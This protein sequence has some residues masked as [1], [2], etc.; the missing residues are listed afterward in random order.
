MFAPDK[1]TG[2]QSEV[3]VA[4]RCVSLSK[5]TKRKNGYTHRHTH[6]QTNARTCKLALIVVPECVK[7]C[8]C[9]SHHNSQII[10]ADIQALIAS[11]M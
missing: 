8:L 4:S 1:A 7:T 5:E 9:H 10:E 3:Q 6:G 2:A 11:V